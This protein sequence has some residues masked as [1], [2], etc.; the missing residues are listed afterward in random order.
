[1]YV[2]ARLAKL[3]I[4]HVLAN[5][6]TKQKGELSAYDGSFSKCVEKLERKMLLYNR[7]PK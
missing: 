5:Q 3:K 7:I 2:N 6:G 4:A 1:M